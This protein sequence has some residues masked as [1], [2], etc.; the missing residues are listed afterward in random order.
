MT[1][2]YADYTRCIKCYRLFLKNGKNICKDCLLREKSQN[3]NY[4][5]NLSS[6]LE[7]LKSNFC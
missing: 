1:K 3:T 5:W 6:L 2:Y 4:T 7:S